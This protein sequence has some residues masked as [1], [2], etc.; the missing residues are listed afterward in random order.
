MF[1]Q[2]GYIT[3]QASQQISIYVQSQLNNDWTHNT[4]QTKLNA[5]SNKNNQYEQYW[6]AITS[7]LSK[8]SVKYELFA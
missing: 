4:E 3:R 6:I 1:V 5:Y 7:T 2:W 8:F